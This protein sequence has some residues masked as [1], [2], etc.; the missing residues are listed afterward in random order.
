MYRVYFAPCTSCSE[1]ITSPH[2]K[3]ELY[4]KSILSSVTQSVKNKLDFSHFLLIIMLRLLIDTLHKGSN[5][6]VHGVWSCK[7]EKEQQQQKD[8]CVRK[9]HGCHFYRV[10]EKRAVSRRGTLPSS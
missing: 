3:L 4:G 2:K 8:Q 6:F 1:S 7:G 10:R 5:R 9:N